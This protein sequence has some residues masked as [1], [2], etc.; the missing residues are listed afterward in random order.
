LTKLL[1]L[2]IPIFV[3]FT[4]YIFL[5]ANG[6][7]DMFYLRFTTPRFCSLVLG[8]SKAAQGIKP[9]VFNDSQM[10]FDRTIYNFS[11]TIGDSLWGSVYLEAIKKKLNPKT[12]HGL[13][14]LEVNPV[15]LSINKH[16]EDWP[17]KKNCV[18]NYFVTLNPNLEYM[19]KYYQDP[20]YKLALFRRSQ[21]HEFLKEDGW[22]QLNVPMD[23]TSVGKR[24]KRKFKEYSQKFT[25]IEFSRTRFEYLK[26][27]IAY[28]K[29]HGRVVLVRLPSS[30]EMRDLEF[31]YMP[32]FDS[33]MESLVNEFHQTYI[34]MIEDYAN[35]QTTDGNHLYKDSAERASREILGQISGSFEIVEK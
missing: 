1:L 4:G 14:I 7:S 18:N 17:E 24:K 31:A 25:E 3:F 6:S 30:K 5:F 19:I 13:F 16:K 26:K 15:T 22:A 23:Q 10:S 21:N 33:E 32:N 27:T 34:N 20:L 9:S 28:L 35:Y 29:S 12:K 11:F 2:L 8:S